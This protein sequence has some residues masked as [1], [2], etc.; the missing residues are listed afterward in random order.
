MDLMSIVILTTV[1]AVVAYFIGSTSSY[2]LTRLF[3]KKVTLFNCLF[4]PWRND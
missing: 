4:K 3:N 2:F 1:G